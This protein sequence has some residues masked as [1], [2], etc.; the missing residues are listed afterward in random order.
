MRFE[1]VNIDIPT[2]SRKE[3]LRKEEIEEW[4]G[5]MCKEI[6][7][8]GFSLYQSS[9]LD[10]RKCTIYCSEQILVN[11]LEFINKNQLSKN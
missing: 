6:F 9:E 2:L 5:F 11:I 4:L 7:S 10:F 8:A 1:Q 3:Q